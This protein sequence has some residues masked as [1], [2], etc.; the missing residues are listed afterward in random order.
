MKD[1]GDDCEILIVAWFNNNFLTVNADKHHLFLLGCNAEHVFGSVGGATIR[2]ENSARLL[3]NLIDSN[4]SFN[5]HVKTMC[6]KVSQKLTVLL[7]MAKIIRGEQRM[8]LVNIF[9]D[10]QSNYCPL[11]FCCLYAFTSYISIYS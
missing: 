6:K 4:L 9:F 2:E 7:R 3:G 5:E 8:V 10:S 11:V 1:M